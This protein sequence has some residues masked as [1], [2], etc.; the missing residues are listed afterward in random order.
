MSKSDLNKLFQEILTDQTLQAKFQETN[1]NNDRES[2][3][4]MI[5]QL[6]EERGYSFTVDEAR[7]SLEE[8]IA[9]PSED[10]ELSD[11]Q[12]ESVAGGIADDAITMFTDNWGCASV[13]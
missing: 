12:L 2:A 9:L 11:K 6:G 7:A 10:R 5:V 13:F 4:K 3:A 1:E 8:L